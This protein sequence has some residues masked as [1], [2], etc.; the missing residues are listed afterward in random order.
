MHNKRY[1]LIAYTVMPN[2]VHL[3]VKTYENFDLKQIVHSW[4]SYTA[5]EIKKEIAGKLPALPAKVWQCDYWDRFIRDENHFKK[6]IEY[7]HNNPVKAGLVKLPEKW[8][9]SSLNGLK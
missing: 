4:K 2:H 8:E 9:W 5:N 3:L 7:I 6:A 1:D